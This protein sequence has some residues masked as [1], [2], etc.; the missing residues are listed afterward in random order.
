M[1]RYSVGLLLLLGCQ[2]AKITP[3]K[4]PFYLY[5][6][7][8]GLIEGQDTFY[9]LIPVAWLFPYPDYYGTFS[10]PQQ[11]PLPASLGERWLFIG[12]GVHENGQQLRPQRYPFFQFDSIYIRTEPEGYL[13]Y[14][15]F[16]RY[17]ADTFLYKPYEEDFEGLGINFEHFSPRADSVTMTFTNDAYRGNQALVIYFDSLNHVL[18][19]VSSKAFTLQRKGSPTWLEIAIK[20]DILLSV[21]IVWQEGTTVQVYNYVTLVPD[22]YRWKR[23]FINL[24]PLI[25]QTPVN[26]NYRL[27]FYTDSFK[28][29]D[30]LY[31]DALRVL[32]F[33]P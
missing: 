30:T 10:L 12:A 19:V 21:G 29:R 18:E 31:V 27:Y 9:D 14:T 13:S 25:A 4:Y 16:F 11:I 17:Y 23:I 2:S 28:R 3:D 32:Q 22:R 15:P 26:A 6:N 1:W 7:K 5:L 8:G 33:R 24:S 20:G